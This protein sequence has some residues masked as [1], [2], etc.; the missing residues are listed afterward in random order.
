MMNGQDDLP[1]REDDFSSK[2][3]RLILNAIQRLTSRGLF[4]VQD[5]LERCGQ[6]DEAGGKARLTYIC[7]LRHDRDNVAYALEQVHDASRQ[8]RAIEIGAQLHKG[9]ITPDE[10]QQ[11]LEKTGRAR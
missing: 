10:A 4:A 2:P 8:R 5:E 9:E 1:I 6:L 7:D 3:N 11:Q